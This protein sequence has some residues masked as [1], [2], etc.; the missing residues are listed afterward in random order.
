[1][2]KQG[3][4]FVNYSQYFFVCVVGIQFLLLLFTC[5]TAWPE[6]ILWPYLILKGWL[7]Y[8]DIAIAHT[9]LLLLDLTIF[10]KLFGLGVTQLKIF[11][12]LYI[13]ATDLV[14]YW[15]VK[16]LLSGVKALVS[17]VM[18][19]FLSLGFQ[20]N[21][22]WFDLGLVLP[23]ILIF[24]F[25][26]TKKYFWVGVIWTV[27]F[28]TKQTAVL[29]LPAIGVWFFVSQRKNFKSFW[30]EAE[31][32]ILTFLIS[33]LAVFLPLAALKILPSFLTWAFQFGVYYLPRAVGQISLPTLK[34]L[35]GV[36]SQ[37]LIVFPY[38]WLFKKKSDLTLLSFVLFLCLGAYPRWEL[39]HFLPALPFLAIVAAEVLVRGAQIKSNLVKW[40]V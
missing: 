13:L 16:K 29:F 3:T 23:A 8:R 26:K 25:L 15:V 4:K 24:Y 35:L 5:F 2:G 17:L 21:G 6:M 7:P 19:V 38:L 18:F 11:T 40:M 22:L 28:F 30:P 34:Q 31:K 10:Y 33:A 37:F 27:A 20:I 36:A 12:W 32:I 9:P 1:M 39:F 14:F